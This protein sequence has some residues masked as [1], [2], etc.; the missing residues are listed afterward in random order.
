MQRFLD[1]LRKLAAEGRGGQAATQQRERDAIDVI[2]L[3]GGS[4]QT[5]P[6]FRWGSDGLWPADNRLFPNGQRSTRT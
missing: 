5:F 4:P 6:S 3:R 2:P 1:E